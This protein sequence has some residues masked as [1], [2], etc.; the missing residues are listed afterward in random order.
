VEGGTGEG[1]RLAIARHV[2]EDTC[3]ALNGDQTTSIRLDSMLRRHMQNNATATIAVFYPRL[4]FGLVKV[5]RRD[6]CL[7]FLEKPVLND[8]F[9]STGVYVF[10]HEIS[11]LL[12]LR[13]D[14]ERAIFPQSW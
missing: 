12:P 14:I 11:K 8:K 1:F 6:R 5:G 4:P 13:E 10:S 9:I 3:F 2:K 7:G